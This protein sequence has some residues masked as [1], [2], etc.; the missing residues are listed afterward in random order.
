VLLG[1]LGPFVR[2]GVSSTLMD[3]NAE[4][5]GVEEEGDAT[6]RAAGRLSPD[7][8]II[9]GDQRGSALLSERLRAAAPAAKLIFCPSDERIEVLDPGTSLVRRC[10]ATAAEGLR[11]ELSRGHH[12]PEE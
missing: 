11:L 6:V 9:G 5:V 4:I 10:P 3:G 7:V 8:I 12:D 1:P 2:L